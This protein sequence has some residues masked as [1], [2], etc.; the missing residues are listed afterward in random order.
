MAFH[1]SVGMSDFGTLRLDGNYY[2][3]KTELV[4][5]LAEKTRNAVT[6]FTRPRRFGKTLMMS[7]MDCFFNVRKESRKLF[8]G[9]DVTANKEF[10]EKWQ[11]QYPVLFVSF[12]DAEA[13]NFEVAYAKL[14]NIIADLCKS[15]ADIVDFNKVDR[16]DA[17]IF[18][19]LKAQ[20]GNESDVQN[21]LKTLMRM[22]NSV[23]DKKV[24]LLID[25]YDVPLARA[26]EKGSD[27]DRY[28]SNMLSVIKGIMSTALKDNDFLQFAVVTGCLKIAKESIFTG[29][30]N[31][32][33]YSVMD[34]D[35]SEYFGFTETEVNDMLVAADRADKA[36]VVKEWYD[37]YVFGKSSLYCPWDV[38]NYV[39]ALQ[40]RENAKPKNYW[41]NTSSNGVI[42]S[43]VNR[44][45][46]KVKTKFE[47]LLNGG[48][49]TQ[50]ISDELTYG[51]LYDTEDN[52]WSVLLMTGYVTKADANEDSEIVSLKIPNREI[53]SIFQDSVVSY[54][55][56]A[57]N[58][59][60][61]K[62]LFDALWSGDEEGATKAVSDLLWKTI[63]YNDYHEDYYHAFLVGTFVGRGYEV[64]SNKEKGLG[65]PDI[66][67]KDDDNRRA[68]IIEAKKSDRERDLQRDCAEALRQIVDEK[69][70]EG[71]T[72]YTQ[73]LCY[74]VSFFRKQAL[75]R[76]LQRG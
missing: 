54:F 25:E 68:I 4:Y 62:G 15:I 22:M 42:L 11:N 10:C 66:L 67:L 43:F 6:L 44:K 72:G 26:S 19:K 47:T 58:A 21:S 52:L 9:L 14:M 28:Y 32:A 69:Y 38:V 39:S 36:G 48:I 76:V 45:D 56:E 41:K 33:S 7:M 61:I 3:D 50:S 37:G 35:F 23:Y 17:D 73:V 59:D 1:V 49:I 31:F 51:N 60:E 71:L 27:A 24:I 29:T 55:K 40:K 65:R 64:E 2:V 53:A 74:G 46:F 18:T 34:E 20:K 63:S 8:E 16:D 13:E 12:K 30:N 57:V 75:V 70:A 5:E